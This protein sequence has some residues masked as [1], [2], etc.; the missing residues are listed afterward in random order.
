[1][2]VSVNVAEGDR[3]GVKLALSVGVGLALAE[4][5]KLGVN[6]LVGRSV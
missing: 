2:D 5:V 1:V 4:A 3:V 6:V